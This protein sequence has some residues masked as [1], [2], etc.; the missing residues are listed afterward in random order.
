M[1]KDFRAETLCFEVV[2]FK[3]GF[4][5]LL[6]QPAFTK[7][8]AISCYA[9][10]KL[11]MPGPN[12]VITISGGPKNAYKVEVANLELAEVEVTTAELMDASTSKETSAMAPPKKMRP[13]SERQLDNTTP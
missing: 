8:I 10:M 7:F 11:K 2:P 1:A 5:A 13:S 9:Y 6:S 4:H 3:G 12:G